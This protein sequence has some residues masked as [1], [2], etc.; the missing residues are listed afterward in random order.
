MKLHCTEN[1]QSCEARTHAINT[2]V[3]PAN[4]LAVTTAINYNDNYYDDHNNNNNN[5]N[6][7]DNNNNNNNNNNYDN[8]NNDNFLVFD[9]ERVR[10]ASDGKFL[11]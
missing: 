7:D 10:S 6:N 4:H 8:N 2:A 9:H 11:G 1:L 3:C 5:N